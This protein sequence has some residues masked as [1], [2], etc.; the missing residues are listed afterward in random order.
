[1]MKM[2]A[3]RNY[4]ITLNGCS[5]SRGSDTVE[6]VE[7]VGFRFEVTF[8][9]GRRENRLSLNMT[10]LALF[11]AMAGAMPIVQRY[12]EEHAVQVLKDSLNKEEMELIRQRRSKS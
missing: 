4:E 1:M 9:D 12:E 3:T 6:I 2:D 11:Q 8:R 5:G 7:T 10:E